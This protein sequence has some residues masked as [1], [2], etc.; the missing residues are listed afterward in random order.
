MGWEDLKR[1]LKERYL[2]LNY[3]ALKMNKFLS[4]VKKGWGIEVYYKEFVNLSRHAPH[5][6]KDQKLGRF[7]LGL[8]GQLAK[9]INGLQPSSLA[10]ALIHEKVKLV[11]FA[12]GERKR[13]QSFPPS[14]SFR[15]QKIA[16]PI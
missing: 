10:V 9:E 3:S 4:F 14:N 5:M 16:I 7:I 13:L 2:P 1:R 12:S 8:E 6:T 11:N 15:P